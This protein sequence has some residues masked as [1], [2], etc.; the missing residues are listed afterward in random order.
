MTTYLSYNIPVL[1]INHEVRISLCLTTGNE[2]ESVPEVVH[3]SQ[4]AG[5]Y[6]MYT[7][8]FGVIED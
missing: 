4:K 8:A 7:R 1:K 5:V 3:E 2:I 6:K